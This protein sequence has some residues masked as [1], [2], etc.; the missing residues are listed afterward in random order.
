[1]AVFFVLRVVAD[2]TSAGWVRWLT[3]LGWAEEMRPFGGAQ[4]LVLLLPLVTTA[5]LL[6]VAWRVGAARD[7]GTGLLP[8]RDSADPDLRLLSSPTALALRAERGSLIAWIVSVGAFG[9]ILGTIS[10]SISSAVVSSSVQKEIA[11]LGTGSILTPT[12]YL[13]FVFI[14]VILVVSL[15]ACAQIA[16]ARH[17]EAEERLETLFAG[18]VGREHWLGGRLVLAMAGMAAVAVSAGVF[19][20][21]GAAV[22]GA[23][24]APLR[25]VEAAL[26]TLP[27]AV[28]F[29]GLAALAYALVPR[30]SAA[31]AYGLVTVAYLWQLVGSLLG[32]PSW[33]VGLTPF[34]HVGLV[35]AQPFRAAAAAVMVAIGVACALVALIGFRRR[36]LL[37]A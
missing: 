34:A 6:V 26:N 15:F 14:I 29:L 23:D 7:I 28:V 4:P 12:G 37:G 31:V 16:A 24:V 9:F 22:A 27:V 20:W 30:A 11:K 36:D 35:P 1:V 21:A 5:V 19:T 13:A 18:P 2:T 10:K 25:M 33:L 17:E 3:P 32:A 8:A